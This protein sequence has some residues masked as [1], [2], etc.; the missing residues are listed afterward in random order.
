MKK[1]TFKRFN[2]AAAL[3]GLGADIKSLAK[4]STLGDQE[5]ARAYHIGTHTVS[6]V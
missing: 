1:Q 6:N 2:T 3:M 4:N 5:L